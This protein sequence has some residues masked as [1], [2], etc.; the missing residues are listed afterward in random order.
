MSSLASLESAATAA[1]AEWRRAIDTAG[2]AVRQHAILSVAAEAP[3]WTESG[4]TLASGDAVTLLSQGVVWL[5]R[6]HGIGFEGTAALWYR[7]G[8]GP[9][10]RVGDRST[11]FVA[12]RAGPLR[13]AARAPGPWLEQPDAAAGGD[14]WAGS[15]GI[16]VAAIVWH[17]GLDAGLTALAAADRDGLG[18]AEAAR[19]AAAVP[20]P[21]GWHPHPVIGRSA[22]FTAGPLDGHRHGINCHCAQDVGIL[23]YPVDVPLDATTRLD[24]SWRMTRLPSSVA[25]NQMPTHDYLSIAVEFENGLDLTYLWSSSLPVGTHFRCPLPYWDQRETHWVVRSGAAELG[26]W[27]D[28]KRPILEDYRA[29]IGGPDPARVVAVWLIAVSLFQRDVGDCAY[30]GIALSNADGI[31]ATVI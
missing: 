14:G 10:E 15:G 4:L 13:L 12:D 2:R 19:H 8:D 31:A 9:V 30:A 3:Q 6:D 5:S 20:P 7:I 16:A 11:S 26:R 29:A 18:A 27:L 23:Q 21:A 24:W 22:I 1:A 28:E 25:E 17:G